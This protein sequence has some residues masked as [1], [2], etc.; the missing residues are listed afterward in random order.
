VFTAEYAQ[1]KTMTIDHT[2]RGFYADAAVL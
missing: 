1:E 2:K